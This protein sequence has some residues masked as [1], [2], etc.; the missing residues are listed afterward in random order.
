MQ[1]SNLTGEEKK[2]KKNISN[3]IPSGEG[4]P[5]YDY[6]TGR[7]TKSPITMRE[8]ELL[9][10]TV[11][12]TTDD[13]KYMRMSIDILK[14]QTDDL[15][16]VWM[17]F[18]SVYPH[19]AVYFS[20]P[21]DQKTNKDYM[22]VV[23]L[24]FKQWVIDTARAEYD[25]KWLDYQHEIGLRHHRTKKNKTDGVDAAPHIH[26]RYIPAFI[27]PITATLKPFLS[28]KHD[29]SAEDVECMHQAWVKSVILQV[30]LWSQVY[31]KD[32]DF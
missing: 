30:C 10:Q 1:H 18:I 28:K 21:S 5:G 25:Q 13:Q 14:D 23:R 17:S 11:L 15:L 16:D 26:Y 3:E 9:K 19:L 22:N 20:S 27:Y 7:V 31:V 2:G 32:G 24:R 8:F 12:W 6:G 4:I 29:V